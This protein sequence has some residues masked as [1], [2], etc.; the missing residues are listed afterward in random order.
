MRSE[1]ARSL[2]TASIAILVDNANPMKPSLLG[3]ARVRTQACRNLRIASSLCF[4]SI[5]I[6]GTL[7]KADGMTSIRSA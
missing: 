3:A 7:A 6:H 1:E 4:A 5:S 2:Q